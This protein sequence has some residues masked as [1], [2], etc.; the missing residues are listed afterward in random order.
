MR[1]YLLGTHHL[2]VSMCHLTRN[3]IFCLN[4]SADH[5]TYNVVPFMLVICLFGYLYPACGPHEF[6]HKRLKL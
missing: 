4:N 2:L 5:D 1:L 6:H 3:L